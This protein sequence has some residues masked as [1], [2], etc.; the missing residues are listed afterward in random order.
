MKVRLA[1]VLEEC[2]ERGVRGALLNES[3][4]KYSDGEY[5]IEYLVDRYVQRVMNEVDDYFTFN[6]D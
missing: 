4:P 3:P 1:V 2:I 6:E 5:N